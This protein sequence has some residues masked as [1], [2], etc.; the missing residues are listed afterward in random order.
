M[1]ALVL[2][3]VRFN[4]CPNYFSTKDVKVKS[5]SVTIIDSIKLKGAIDESINDDKLPLCLSD[6]GVSLRDYF[7]VVNKVYTADE[8]VYIKG[9]QLYQ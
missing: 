1:N 4:L 8:G 7:A 6:T 3:T 5:G 9:E 2:K